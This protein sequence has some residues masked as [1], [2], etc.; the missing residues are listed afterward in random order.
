MEKKKEKDNYRDFWKGV[1]PVLDDAPMK[2]L[3]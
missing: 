2:M 1:V 3:L